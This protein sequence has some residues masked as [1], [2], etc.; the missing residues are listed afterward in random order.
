MPPRMIEELERIRYRQGQVLSARDLQ[1]DQEFAALLR[2]MHTRYLHG[3]WGIAAGLDVTISQ[4]DEVARVS[5]GIA[6]DGYGREIVLSE[7]VEIP[8]PDLEML[9]A[10][11]LAVRYKDRAEFPSRAEVQGVCLPDESGDQ[12]QAVFTGL[13]ERPV[14]LW[15]R[16]GT[17]RLGEEVPLGRVRRIPF[18]IASMVVLDKNVRRYATALARPK[19][20][21]GLALVDPASMRP[22]TET[23]GQANP[24]LVGLQAEVDTSAAGFGRTPCYIHRAQL[25]YQLRQGQFT[26][27]VPGFDSLADAQP[28]RFTFRIMLAA[29]FTTLSSG[30][31]AAPGFMA[32]ASLF[33]VQPAAAQAQ[34]TIRVAIHWLG[35]ESD[36]AHP[37]G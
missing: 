20:G 30:P 2:W 34:V 7:A 17:V 11:D 33:A 14:F 23:V 19:I 26:I 25:Q 36:P 28:G 3:T 29:L 22:W 15:R 32:A 37:G 18:M 12:G 6:T 4:T 8:L 35:I 16:P 10:R 13:R 9:E 21:H 1:D 5:P 31:G 27:P 24:V